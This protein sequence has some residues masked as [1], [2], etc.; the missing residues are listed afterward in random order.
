MIMLV[1]VDNR[2]LGDNMSIAADNMCVV[3]ADMLVVS[4]MSSCC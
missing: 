1:A 3:V 4:K 2:A